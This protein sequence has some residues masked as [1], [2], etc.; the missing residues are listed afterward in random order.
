MTATAAEADVVLPAQSWAEREGTF[1]SG[2]RRVQRFYPGIPAIGQ[3]RP[4]WLIL[5]QIGDRINMGKP[6]SASSLLFREIAQ[7]VPQYRGMDYRSLA[8]TEKQWPDVG[9]EDLYYG[10]NAYENRSGLGQQW[11]VTSEA[12]DVERYETPD[13]AV[14]ES[15]KLQVMGTVKLY[16]AG[17]R[18][19]HSQVVSSH[20]GP[21]TLA[22]HP[23]DAE[24]AQ[25]KDGDLVS[26]GL[27]DN[28]M[29]LRAKVTGDAA[30]GLA[31]LSGMKTRPGLFEADIRGLEVAEKELA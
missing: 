4:D 7:A 8:V 16:A 28:N 19:G 18:I 20:I 2:E 14:G 15:E 31:L 23:F 12:Q 17:T 5:A 25:I 6:A 1:T 21:P 27:D 26:L 11:A 22:L 30:V 3:C 24:E 13:L 10:G 29:K 9:G